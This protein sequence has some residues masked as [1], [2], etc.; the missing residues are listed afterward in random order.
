M[1]FVALDLLGAVIKYLLEGVEDFRGVAFE[2]FFGI[3][4]D[5]LK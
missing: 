2:I 4:Q 3:F 5:D 1:F